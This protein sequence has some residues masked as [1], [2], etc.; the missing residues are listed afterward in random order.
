[1]DIEFLDSSREA[2]E[3]GFFDIRAVFIIPFLG[4]IVMIRLVVVGFEAMRELILLSFEVLS[5][6]GVDKVG[7]FDEYCTA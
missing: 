7:I 3:E 2:V 1:M 6:I 4:V 5:G